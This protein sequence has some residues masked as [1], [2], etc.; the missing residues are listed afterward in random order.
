MVQLVGL[1]LEDWSEKL[2][3]HQIQRRTKTQTHEMELE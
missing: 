1:V 3:A 2:Q